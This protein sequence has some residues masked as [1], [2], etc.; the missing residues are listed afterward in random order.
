MN[1]NKKWAELLEAI[2]S[3]GSINKSS[4]DLGITFKTAWSRLER[5]KNTYPELHI[6]NTEI[7]G[8]TRGG[9][10]LTSQ[11]RELLKK[12]KNI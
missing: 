9:T 2:D 3:T 6:V 8:A 5:L 1:Y 7:G 4:K 12:L 11:G 10:Y